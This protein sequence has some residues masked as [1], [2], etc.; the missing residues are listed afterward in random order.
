MYNFRLNL[1]NI[2]LIPRLER[3]GNIA[4]AASAFR[5]LDYGFLSVFL[6]VYLSFLDFTVFQAGLVFSAIMAGGALSNLVASW[7]GD[8]IG[9][10]R[11]LVVMSGLMALGGVLFPFAS[12]VT[13]LII[14]S[15]F[16]MTTSTGGD[17]TAFLS[18]DMAILAQTS[19]AT[20]RTTVFSW[21]NIVGIGAK[22][23]GALFIA[24]PALLQSGI[25]VGELTSFKVVFGLYSF[26]ALC[27]LIIYTRL[28]P[29]AE[30]NKSQTRNEEVVKRG[31]KNSRGIIIQLVGLFSM[32]ALG[33]GF[34]V[35]SF[36][37][38]WFVSR[39]GVD[40][41]SIALIFFAGQALNAVSVWLAAPI[42]HRIGLINTM[43]STQIVSNILMGAMAFT[44][45]LWMA[46]AFYLARELSNDM[47]VPTRQSYMMAVVPPE[48]R[49]ATASVTNL[50]RTVAQTLSP[51][52]A[53]YVAQIT[54]LGAPFLIGSGIKLVYNVALYLMFRGVKSPDEVAQDEEVVSYPAQGS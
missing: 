27:G 49:T 53:G 37:S 24:V 10:R 39:F 50:G 23:L 45:N 32:D 6:G 47:D 17:R 41:N 3:D 26:I 40:L 52:T 28:S 35:R 2:Y 46:V 16:A 15:L 22:A 34:M 33:G 30:L 7:K 12:S 13:L 1:K 5:A 48:S 25:G 29:R 20:Q 31:Q 18:L 54:F 36:V 42:A 21:Y 14:I 11:M 9:R 43:V 4:V 19:D 51:G 44:G 8:T 38:F